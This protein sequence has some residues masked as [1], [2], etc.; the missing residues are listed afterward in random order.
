MAKDFVQVEKEL[1][2]ILN[3]VKTVVFQGHKFDVAVVDKPSSEKGEPKTDIYVQLK[4]KNI[5]KEIKVSV[6][7][8]MQ[9]F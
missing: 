7:K 9:I 2:K 8:I 1:V 3:R 6:K 5:I 4:N